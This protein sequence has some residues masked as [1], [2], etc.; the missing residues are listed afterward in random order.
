MGNIAILIIQVGM[1]TLLYGLIYLWYLRPRLID[2][3]LLVALQPL[4]FVQAFRWTGLTLIAE[5]QVDPSLPSDRLAAAS[6]GDLT[7]AVIAIAALLLA[8]G[9]HRLTVPVA[10]VLTVVG[11]ADFVNVGIIAVETDML[12]RDLG[13]MWVI[14]GW[15]V[16]AVTVSHV[17]IID[18]L[19]SSRRS[20]AEAGRPPQRGTTVSGSPGGRLPGPLA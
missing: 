15:Y 20:T 18:Q 12:S 10:W 16:S 14:L 13:A 6:Y 2:R 17:A 8:R 4:L 9:Q 3:P 19:V 11:L 5:G 7:A 1:A